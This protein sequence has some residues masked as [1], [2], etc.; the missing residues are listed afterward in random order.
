MP[1]LAVWITIL[2]DL[3]VDAECIEGVPWEAEWLWQRIRTRGSSNRGK[4]RRNARARGTDGAKTEV[5]GPFDP[6]EADKASGPRSRTIE[7][8]PRLP[9]PHRCHCVIGVLCH[10]YQQKYPDLRPG[11][12]DRMELRDSNPYT[13][14]VTLGC[15]SISINKKTQTC[16][17]AFLIGWS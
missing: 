1:R 12:F 15:S 5:D 4:G 2:M 8:E 17:Q 6:M 7:P 13:P 16:V 11:F 9:S 3:T 14:T 10:F